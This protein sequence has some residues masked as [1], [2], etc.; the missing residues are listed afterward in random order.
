MSPSRRAKCDWL[1]GNKF[2]FYDTFGMTLIEAEACGIPVF[3][4]DPDM[5][6]VVPKGG[7]VMAS[8]PGSDE[9]AAALTNLIAHPERIKQMSEVMIKHRKEVLMSQKIKMLLKIFENLK[10]TV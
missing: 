6:E 3:F 2:D 9:M 4:C 8:G 5:E 1:E 10:D 7:Y